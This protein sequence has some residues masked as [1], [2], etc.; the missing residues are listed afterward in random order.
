MPVDFAATALMRLR[1]FLLGMTVLTLS[2]IVTAQSA[3]NSQASPDEAAPPFDINTIDP[4]TFQAVATRLPEGLEPEIDGVMN[5][6]A[7]AL[8]TPS[9]DFIQREPS[10]GSLST[11]RTEFRILYD[12]RHLYFG[13]W[14]YDSNPDGILASEMKRD[15][16]LFRGDQ[17]KI[18]IDTFHDHRNGVYFATNPLGARKDATSVQ[19]GRTLN[20]DFNV[21][22]RCKTS[23]DD[24]GWYAEIAIPLSQLPFKSA[25]GETTW[26]LNVCRVIM[27]KNEETYWVPFPREWGAPGLARMSRAGNIIG[28]KDIQSRRRLELV[29]YIRPQ[30]FRDYT[31]DTS[32]EK[33]MGYG[34]D[35]RLGITSDLDAVLTYKTDFAHVEADQ[36]IVNLTRFSLYFPEKREFFTRTASVFEY[37]NTGSRFLGSA[38]ADYAGTVTGTGLLSLFY[39][40]RIGLYEGREVPIL[41]GGRVTGR[42]GPYT[43]G[44]MNIETDET[45]FVSDSGEEV[46]VPRANYTVMRVKR[47]I[48]AQSNVGAIFTNRQGG[49]GA[50]YN[51]SVGL[52]AGFNLGTA[53]KL[54]ALLAK[55]FS[56]DVSEKDMAGALDFSWKNDRFD[57]GATYLDIGEQFNAEMGFVPRID[58]RNA[59]GSAA[60]TPR[61]GWK[62]VRQ[63]T[64]GGAVDYYENHA[65]RMESRNQSGRF[66]MDFQDSS[67][68]QIGG[69]H[70]YDYVPYDW[71]TG[72]GII[73]TGAYQWNTFRAIY[74]SN[75]SRPVSVGA[76][77][78]LGG[79]YSGKKQ[80]Y[81]FGLNLLFAKTLLVESNYTRNEI[82]LPD[83]PEFTTNTINTRISYSVSPD[84]YLKTFLQ[85]NDER[86]LANFNFLLWYIYRPGSDLYIVYNQGWGTEPH[87]FHTRDRSLTVKLTYWLS[88]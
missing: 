2:G 15:S 82:T 37:G 78:E 40:R 3:E 58:V 45:Q 59:K 12:D 74:N 9:G 28:F 83:E 84:L 50:E 69:D 56:P 17:I 43:M 71:Q 77:V 67:N 21:V 8:A 7:W 30:L 80:S 73:P 26:G 16:G 88:R 57:F 1:P 66:R 62:G 11:E 70:D 42:T 35:F 64:F 81:L 76:T 47:D 52:D 63:L 24:K 65:G 39:S 86:S 61:P 75:R 41:I 54:T 27:R 38:A 31:T 6:E 18:N 14:A 34:F 20:Y 5:D 23:R 53:T 46:F 25:I 48:L 85:Y 36:E 72:G 19:E 87:N 44:F 32:T 29:P 4:D 22:W 51:R 68:L 13:I 33:E 55:T 79:Y 10:Y 60:W 49:A